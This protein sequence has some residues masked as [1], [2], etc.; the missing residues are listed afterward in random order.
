MGDGVDIPALGE[1]G[2]A[3]HALHVFAELA[4]LANGVHDLTEKVFISQAFRISTGEAGEVF[5]LE[6]IDFS[7][8]DLLEVVGH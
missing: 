5:G 4:R 8:G 7:G 6:F 2:D 1:H 3:D